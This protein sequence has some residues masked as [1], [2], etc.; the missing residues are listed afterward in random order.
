[1][2]LD[3]FFTKH[4]AN[5]LN[6]NLKGASIKR[7]YNISNHEFL[8]KMQNKKNLYINVSNECRVNITAKNF[9][10]PDKPANFTMILRKYLKTFKITNIIN[11]N[12]DRIIKI[13]FSGLN[14]LKDYVTYILYIELFNRYSNIILTDENNMIIS[15]LKFSNSEKRTILTNYQY[16]VRQNTN[17][18][19]TPTISKLFQEQQSLFENLRPCLIKNDFYFCNIFKNPEYFNSLS[20]LLESYYFDSDKK[21]RVSFLAN[22][23]SKKIGNEL[24][25]LEKKLCKLEKQYRLNQDFIKYKLYGDLILTYGYQNQDKNILVCNDY[26]GNQVKITL[27]KNLDTSNNANKYY[28]KYQKLKR[29]LIHI[30]TQ[31]EITNQRIDY[32]NNLLFQISISN[33]AELVEIASEFNQKQTKKIEKKSKIHI[34]KSDEFSIYIGKNNLQNEEITFKLSR[35]NDYWFHVKDLPGS[36]VLLK[37]NNLTDDLVNYTASI[38]AFY[39]KGATYPNVDVMYTNIKNVKKVS[40]SYPGHVSII[41]DFKVVNVCPKDK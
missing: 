9:V 41:N 34:I 25:K 38:A 33:E 15:A 40:K 27:D 28:Q 2:P 32:L 11:Y 5:E 20:E 18:I 17:Y 6:E 39:S 13:S 30:K 10:F 3:S 37:T 7:I 22:S 8:F 36:H 19:T 31:T 4:L 23:C 16:K 26:D 12:K 35:K 21:R 1:M 14:E 24:K 29:S